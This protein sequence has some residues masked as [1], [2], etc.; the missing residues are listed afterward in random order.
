MTGPIEIRA[1][2]PGWDNQWVTLDFGHYPAGEPYVK[3][4]PYGADRGF[5]LLVR[6]ADIGVLN[7]ALMFV[8][9]MKWRHGDIPVELHLPHFPGARQDRLNADGDLLFTAK[10]VANMINQRGFRVVYVVDPHSEVLTALVDNVRVVTALDCLVSCTDA[11]IKGRWAGIIA[12]DGGAEKRALQ[13][14]TYLNIP[15]YQA[16]K[17]RDVATGK[18]AGFGCQE[19]PPS[20]KPYLV[21]DDLC[22][23]G[24]TFMGL[25]GVVADGV[26][27]DLYVS[28]GLFTKGIETL[29]LAF[30]EIYTTDSIV[31]VPADAVCIEVA[32]HLKEIQR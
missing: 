6:T 1:S 21:V 30:S 10:S 24:G 13:V 12:P 8:D 5:D 17:N 2:H 25:A 31:L 3:D 4:V 22:D 7:E 26:T 9:A 19:I 29:A 28:H 15:L 32:R 23:G 16:W 11:Q 20:D 14:A 18:I 27:L